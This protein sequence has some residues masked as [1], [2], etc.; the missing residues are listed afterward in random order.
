MEALLMAE[1]KTKQDKK[2]RLLALRDYLYKYTDEQ[3]PVSTQELIDEM[4][5]QG[6]PGNRKTIKDDIDVL[7]KFGMDIITNVSRGNSFY[8]ASREFEIPELKLLV[9]AVS[10]SRFISAARSEQLI[11]KLTAMASEYEKEQITPRIFTGDRIKANNPHL[12]YVVDMLIQ[13]IQNKKKVRFQYGEFDADKH[14]VLRN[15]GE[16]YINSPY[17]CL[18]NDDFY[19]LV[20]Y[21]EKREKVVTFRVDRIVDLEI[22][23]DDIIPEPADFDMSD[24]AK[25]VI[26]MF[27]GEPQEVELLCD[28]ELMKSVIDKFGENIKTER[29]SDEQFKAVVNV[30]TSKTFYAWCFRFAEQMKIVGPENVKNTYIE[31]A[32]SVIG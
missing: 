14:K 1:E 30:S 20:G 6:Y 2:G 28:N 13:A 31:M 27:D 21:S 5:R 25:I 18:W 26:E 7:N 32:R 24:Y 3:H 19:Y 8:M 4:T 16:I 11:G 9:D 23:D 10:S 12:Y 15:D 22:M 17:G 29:V